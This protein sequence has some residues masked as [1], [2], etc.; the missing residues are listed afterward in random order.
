[1]T[2]ALDKALLTLLKACPDDDKSKG[3]KKPPQKGDNDQDAQSAE[4]DKA[5]AKN[6]FEEAQDQ[7]AAEGAEDEDGAGDDDG[8]M[9]VGGQQ[10]SDDGSGDDDESDGPPMGQDGQQ[11]GGGDVAGLVQQIA[12]AEEDFYAARGAHGDGHHRTDAAM[13]TL[14][15]LMRKL[16]RQVGGQMPQV[17]KPGAPGADGD[18]AGPPNQNEGKGALP[19]EQGDDEGD[20]QEGGDASAEKWGADDKGD[21]DGEDGGDEESGGK[22]SPPPFK[23]KGSG[24]A[25]DKTKKS[26]GDGIEAL[27]KSLV[28]KQDMI[29]HRPPPPRPPPAAPPAPKMS[30]EMI[31]LTEGPNE[32]GGFIDWAGMFGKVGA[33]MAEA[34]ADGH[35]SAMFGRATGHGKVPGM[36]VAHMTYQEPAAAMGEDA[37]PPSP[38]MPFM[39]QLQAFYGEQGTSAEPELY[40]FEGFMAAPPQPH[41]GHAKTPP[42]GRMGG[43]QPTRG[44]KSLDSIDD[45]L[46]ALWKAVSPTPVKDAVS[47]TPARVPPIG[48][49]GGEGSRGGKVVGHTAGGKA[50]YERH[51]EKAEKASHH[52]NATGSAEAHDR[53][54]LLH[55]KAENEVFNNFGE[56]SAKARDLADNHAQA[57]AYHR[58]VAT[59]QRGGAKAVYKK[60]AQDAAE[61][62]SR[63]KKRD[64]AR[65]HSV[66][67][68]AHQRAEQVVFDHFSPDSKHAQRLSDYHAHHAAVHHDRALL[69]SA[70]GHP[71]PKAKK[72]EDAIDQYGRALVKGGLWQFTNPPQGYGNV[73]DDYL[74]DYLIAFVYEAYKAATFDQNPKSDAHSYACAVM[75]ELIGALPSNRNLK[76]AASKFKV[77]K[78][79]IAKVLLDEGIYTADAPTLAASNQA[80]AQAFYYSQQRPWLQGQPESPGV[81]LYQAAPELVSVMDDVGDPSVALQL[82]KSAQMAA[83]WPG[84]ETVPVANV[85]HTCPIHNGTD[86]TK[87][88]LIFHPALACSCPT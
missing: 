49:M 60:H 72:S 57:A 11:P 39:N 42:V 63:A 19:W 26:G 69:L 50:I 17:G 54:A 84:K 2:T 21:D 4:A 38:A 32:N 47:P 1:M 86:Y 31:Q 24:G 27:M 3:K 45:A 73:P 48:M 36:P 34:S 14:H 29:E 65:S 58:R 44:K 85:S 64:T 53:A 40:D 51:K 59:K 28:G 82:A 7:H 79:L 77:N 25:K 61:A 78:D 46:S 88:Q 13:E 68:R 20:D 62:S 10:Q 12:A 18:Q 41:D 8:P 35:P 87:A 5:K 30:G 71:V 70:H 75:C 9:A 6:P 66:A 76:R 16:V 33:S 15:K 55:R 83:L 81:P 23:K 56:N 80:V 67:A 22:G 52:A 74:W 37:P 43:C